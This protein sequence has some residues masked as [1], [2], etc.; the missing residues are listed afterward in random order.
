MTRHTGC[1]SSTSFGWG[2]GG[3]VTSAGWQVTLCDLLGHV[4]SRSGVVI[5]V[6][7]TF[8]Y[9]TF[10]R[11]LTH[12]IFAMNVRN[13]YALILI[14]VFVLL[15]LVGLRCFSQHHESCILVCTGGLIVV[16]MTG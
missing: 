11:T 6:H 15:L 12:F 13:N 14:I 5:P 1:K 10:Q 2:K 16:K 7:F 4:I 9:F 8:T 3:K